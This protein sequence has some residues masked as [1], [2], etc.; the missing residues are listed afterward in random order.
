MNKTDC[1]PMD[2]GALQSTFYVFQGNLYRSKNNT[3]CSSRMARFTANGEHHRCL[4]NRIIYA[5][6]NEVGNFNYLL[7]DDAGKSV[8][9]SREILAMF[10]YKKYTK[11][12]KYRED[13]WLARWHTAI[14]GRGAKSFKT[15]KEALSYQKNK[16]IAEWKETLVKLNLWEAYN[17]E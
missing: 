12:K 8:E 4:V 17:K 15:H 14:G 11:I 1:I 5:L 10:H 3:L 6:D 13:R 9:V 2:L 16:F 7:K